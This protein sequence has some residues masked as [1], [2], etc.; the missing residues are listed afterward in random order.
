MNTTSINQI[1]C[2]QESY[3]KEEQDTKND[4]N[5]LM[6]LY[7]IYHHVLWDEGFHKYCVESFIG[8]F[9]RL[10]G[11]EKLDD[12]PQE[13][14][15]FLVMK[16]RERGNSNATI[17]RKMAALSKLLKKAHRMGDIGSLPE[18]HRLKERAGRIRF[19]E[20]DEEEQLFAAI[21]ARSEDY[22]RLSVFL[23][24][25]GARLGEAIGVRWNDIHAGRVTFWITKSGRSRTLP[26]TQR[27]QQVLRASRQSRNGPFLHIGQPK[28][29]ATWH[30]AKK[31]C[32]LGGDADVVPHI[33]RHTCASRLVRGGIDLRRVQTW[34]GHQTLQMTMRYAHLATHDLDTCLPVLERNG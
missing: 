34:L 25:T 15:D 9:D 3:N 17:N 1:S 16:L 32:G 30:E 21:K 14:L 33:L 18:F 10:L 8:E 20:Y 19:L 7:R 4:K 24:D 11:Y 31:E 5:S 29:R 26:L 12:F 28:F 13:K 2:K 23:V 22:Y 27:A 6:N